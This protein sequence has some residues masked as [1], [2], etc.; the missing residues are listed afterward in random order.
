MY[1]YPISFAE[2]QQV[3]KNRGNE[4]TLVSICI[5]PIRRSNMQ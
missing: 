4:Q 2:A 5:H 1:L 3:Y